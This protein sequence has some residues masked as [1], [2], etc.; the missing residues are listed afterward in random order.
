MNMPGNPL[1]GLYVHVPF[2]QRKCPYCD[3][4]SGTDLALV[5]DWLRAIQQEMGLYRDVAPTFDTLYLGGGTPSLLAAEQLAVLLES[6]QEQFTFVPDTEITLEAN[7]DDLTLDI[8]K[9]YR[10][11]GVN[12]LSLGVQSFHDRELNFLGRRHDAAQALRAPAWSREAGFANLGLDLI[13]GLPGQTLDRWK[14]NLETA[15]SFCPEHLS[16]Y[17]L[18]VEAGTPL[19][20]RQAEAQFQLLSEETER[21]FFLFTSRFLE[22]AGYLHYEISNFARG[23]EYRSRHNGKYWN[24]TPYL[25]LG[26]AAH[27][28]RDGRRWWNHRSLKD[29][30]QALSKGEAPVADRETLNPEQTRLEALYLGLRTRE[31]VA[32][33]LLLDARRGKIGLQE[34]VRAGLAEV[35]DGRL[36]PTREGLVV[37]DRL[38]LGFMD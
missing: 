8:L 13:Y 17:Q 2:C 3:F 31:G 18:T 14:R 22:E 5:A 11:L 34:I 15:L 37:A 33:D 19:A 20:R 12:R 10:E 16:C 26:P 32:L 6:L 36:V 1:A 21:E 7:P 4:A 24:H 35:K 38:A 28:Y 29:Y 25:G 23:S 30:C 9:G 27:S